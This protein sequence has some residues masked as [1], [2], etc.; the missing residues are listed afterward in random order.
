MRLFVL[1]CDGDDS[2]KFGT[3][4]FHL[5]RARSDLHRTLE[6]LPTMKN[7]ILAVSAVSAVAASANA[8]FQGFVASVRDVGAYTVIDIFAGVTN[9]SDKFLNAYDMTISTT[10]AGG[11]VQGSSLA[12]KTWKPDAAGFGSTRNTLDSF[13]TAGTFS[14]GQYGSEFYASINTNGDPNFNGTS[15]NGTPASAA[16][17]T[18]PANAGWYTG[19]PTSIDT[20]AESLAGLVGRVNSTGTSSSWGI[21]ISHIVVAGNGRTLGTDV[22][23]SGFA[24]AKDGLS[25]AVSQGASAF[26][27]PAPGAVA[28]LGLA[29]FAARRRRA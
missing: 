22:T 13:M 16:A 28:L 1:A 6:R 24:S 19:D 11:F 17:T 15:W 20:R 7:M 21:W 23:Y 4:R 29:G 25:G 9:Q 14:G 8:G 3:R 12:N 5:C 26:P 2:L 18:V 27:V 10:V